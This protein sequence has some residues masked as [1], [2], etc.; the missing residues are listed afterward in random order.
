MDREG[1]PMAR[2][3]KSKSNKGPGIF[4]T[5]GSRVADFSYH[6]NDALAQMIVDAWTD[7]DFKRVL[8]NS[9]NVKALFAARGFFW[10]STSKKPVVITEDEYN[11]GYAQ[12]HDDEV[13]FVLPDHDGT[14]PP[15]KTLLETARL[16][17]AVTPHG[18]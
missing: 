17:M 18:I 5:D 8:L 10:N 3:S 14:C 11:D 13:V 1:E 15:G 6:P 7:K 12:Q 9:G 2:K 16:L 4:R